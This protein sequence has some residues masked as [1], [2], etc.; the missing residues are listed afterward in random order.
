MEGRIE[1]LQVKA[2]AKDLAKQSG[3][4]GGEEVR[5]EKAIR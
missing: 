2:S 1:K 5:R 4:F 3:R